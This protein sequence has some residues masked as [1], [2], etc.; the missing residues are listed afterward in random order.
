MKLIDWRTA[1]GLSQDKVA[2]AV[3]ASAMS[4]SRIEK[5]AQR[6]S[7]ELAKRIEAYTKGAVTAAA[8]LGIEETRKR[9][10]GV[11]E[12]G[13]AF[14]GAEKITIAVAVSADQ[15]R[16]LQKHGV[17]VEAIAR[18]GAE[19]AVKEAEART[20]AEANK[21][22]IAAYNAWI[23]KHGTLAEQLGLI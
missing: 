7:P 23:D 16:L 18:A 15:A 3:R 13:E 2:R 8:L 19:K 17:D 14:G 21:E 20:W 5:G 9:S 1:Q 4:I 6:P 22:A 12:D 11:R 10:R